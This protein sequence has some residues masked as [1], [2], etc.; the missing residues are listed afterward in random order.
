MNL[1]WFTIIVVVGV[2]IIQML[3]LPDMHSLLKY[4]LSVPWAVILYWVA[5]FLSG[6]FLAIC[7][8]VT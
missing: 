1:T 2:A 5:S 6:Q 4:I 8:V 3:D 7:I